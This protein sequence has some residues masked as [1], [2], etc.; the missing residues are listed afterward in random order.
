MDE[1]IVGGYALPQV[2]TYEG[3]RRLFGSDVP[4]MTLP[5]LLAEKEGVR[6]A[7]TEASADELAGFITTA[8]Q[9]V[10]RLDQ[11]A[12]VRHWLHRRESQ[13]AREIQDRRNRQA[14]PGSGGGQVGIR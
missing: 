14:E 4:G 9:Y 5:E 12:T 7:L 6:R 11:P 2:G 8:D 13:I 10:K 1:V 3:D